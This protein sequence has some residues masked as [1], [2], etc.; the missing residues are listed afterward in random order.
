LSPAADCI[1]TGYSIALGNAK[2]VSRKDFEDSMK[3]HIVAK[4]EYMGRYNKTQK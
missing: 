2:I 1:C 4:A 3:S